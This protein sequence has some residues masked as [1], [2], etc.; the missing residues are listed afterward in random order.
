MSNQSL[1]LISSLKIRLHT[2]AR[3]SVRACVRTCV[4]GKQVGSYHQK[5][6][7]AATT[8]PVF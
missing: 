4:F 1:T 6:K 7:L 8:Q 2:G 3:A 5:S